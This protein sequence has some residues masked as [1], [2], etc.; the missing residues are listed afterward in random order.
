V[1]ARLAR[2]AALAL[3]AAAIACD[4]GGW[5][6]GGA[7]RFEEVDAADA[8]RQIA[9]SAV[10]LIQVRQ[11]DVGD[12]R[13]SGADV[14]T[15]D[16]PLPD[17]ARAADRPIFV[18]AHDDPSARRFASRL[19]RGGFARVFVVRGGVQAWREQRRGLAQ[20]VGVLEFQARCAGRRYT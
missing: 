17:L 19:V 15:P 9:T 5:I 8:A 2:I 4:P 6:L 10:W 14:V 11:P 20:P 18:I 1:P 7:R 3:S 12:P 13:V 16:Q